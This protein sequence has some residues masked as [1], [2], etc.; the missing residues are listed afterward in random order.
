MLYYTN[1]RVAIL[2]SNELEIPFSI[3]LVRLG[4]EKF[5]LWKDPETG[6]CYALSHPFTLSL[7]SLSLSKYT[8]L[9]D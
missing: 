2:L 8:T 6:C 1:K 5:I 9:Y 3:L 4:L 7:I